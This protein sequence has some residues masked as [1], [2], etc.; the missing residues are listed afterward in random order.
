MEPVAFDVCSDLGGND[1]KTLAGI[2]G[3]RRLDRGVQRQQVGLAGD[4]TD[5]LGDVVDIGKRLGEAGDLSADL[6]RGL[7]HVAD[8]GDRARQTVGRFLQHVTSLCR[9]AVGFA[10]RYGDRAVGLGDRKRGTGDIIEGGGMPSR[11]SRH[12]LYG[13]GDIDEIDAKGGSLFGKAQQDMAQRLGIRAF[14]FDRRFSGQIV[15]RLQRMHADAPP[16]QS[17]KLQATWLTSCKQRP[18]LRL[19]L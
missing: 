17:E 5:L 16:P 2:A 18:H 3:A 1:R 10:Q 7:N 12:I 9:R 14:R 15:Y 8:L 13:A 11:H 19:R 6:V 4:G